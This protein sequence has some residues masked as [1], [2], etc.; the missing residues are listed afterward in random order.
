MNKILM[1]CISSIF[2]IH[3]CI[4]QINTIDYETL[5]DT[6]VLERAAVVETYLAKKKE[7]DKRHNI[8]VEEYN[9]IDDTLNDSLICEARIYLEKQFLT[10]IMP[11]WIGTNWTYGGY[12]NFP[13][14]GSIACGWF[15]QRIMEHLDFTFMKHNSKLPYFAQN[16]PKTMV[17]GL[18]SNA[19]IINSDIDSIK[20]DKIQSLPKGI[21]LIGFSASQGVGNHIGFLINAGTE[22]FIIHSLGVVKKVRALEEEY[23]ISSETFYIAMLFN[24]KV[25]TNWME[26]KS[27]EW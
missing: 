24:D 22:L 3:L 27:I 6:P 10:E 13:K 7:V 14:I 21:Y 8:F 1:I 9:S 17:F 23:F 20:Y 25:I 26:C 11:A 18:D 19:Y 5:L 15:V 2:Q 16:W 12:S 4:G